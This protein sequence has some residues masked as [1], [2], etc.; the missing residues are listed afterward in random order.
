MTD[1]IT[2]TIRKVDNQSPS[3]SLNADSARIEL[4]TSEL[5]KAIIYSVTA[6]DNAVSSV[7]I[8]GVEQVSQNGDTYTF[9]E[10]FDYDNYA[11]GNSVVTRT[12]AFTDNA[13]NAVND[14]ITLSL[15][16]IDDQSPSLS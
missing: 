12:V 16:K 3:I 15:A 4:S 9:S 1:S 6:T 11:Y 14:S 5:T 10:T 13:G 2:L 7:S 8:R